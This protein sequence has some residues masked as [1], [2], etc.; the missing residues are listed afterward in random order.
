MLAHLKAKHR[1]QCLPPDGQPVPAQPPTEQPVS[2]VAGA[3]F[4]GHEEL[5]EEDN[6]TQVT[7]DVLCSLSSSYGPPL[8]SEEATCPGMDK[9]KSKTCPKQHQLPM[10]LSKTYHMIDR[11]DPTIATWSAA[12]DNFV[13]KNV[14][15]F[16]SVRFFGDHASWILF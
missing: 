8:D 9:H 15:K 4:E 11:C 10:F 5:Q 7:C 12:G 13:V 16:A 2:P 14:E 6:A 1:E 3:Y